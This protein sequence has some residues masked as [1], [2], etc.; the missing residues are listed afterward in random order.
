MVEV[1]MKAKFVIPLLLL[2]AGCV[3]AD[4]Q[5]LDQVPRPERSPDSIQV[6][7]EKPDRPYTV[8]AVVESKSD[9]VFKNFDD[10]R[11]RMIEEA[12]KLGGD[13]VI[14]GAGDRESSVL[15]LPTGQIHSD[16]KKLRGEVIVFR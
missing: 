14:L 2:V 7:L 6:L 5:R 13:A 16:E 12:A 8:I 9:V 11:S 10:L 4:V 3:R 1:G 15:I